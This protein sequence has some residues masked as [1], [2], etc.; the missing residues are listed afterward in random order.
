MI[1]VFHYFFITL[2]TFPPYN[3]NSDKIRHNSEYPT[4]SAACSTLRT[5]CTIMEAAATYAY[6]S[7]NLYSNIS[8]HHSRA[9]C[10]CRTSCTGRTALFCD[11]FLLRLVVS[12][13]FVTPHHPASSKSLSLKFD[14]CTDCC[15][16]S[17]SCPPV[18]DSRRWPSHQYNSCL[19]L[20][21]T[22][23]MSLGYFHTATSIAAVIITTTIGL[24]RHFCSV[25]RSPSPTPST[26][27][28][29]NCWRV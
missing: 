1:I 6:C 3:S 17:N 26:S 18:A 22:C 4:D 16:E 11:T 23:P 5:S 28:L 19:P 7:D 9:P 10:I 8:Y 15:L 13:Y 25:Y 14:R 24:T 2:V 20:A 27:L 21:C 29:I 12:F